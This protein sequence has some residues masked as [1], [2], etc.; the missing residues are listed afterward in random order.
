MEHAVGV[1]VDPGD[2][3]VV[4]DDCA[5]CALARSSAS[6]RDIERGEH[7][8]PVEEPVVDAVVARVGADH[9]PMS[10]M[11]STD[12]LAAPGTLILVK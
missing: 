1:D 5:H 6:A 4:V 9:Q 8:V 10:L 2:H 7:L 11:P 12:V 3:A